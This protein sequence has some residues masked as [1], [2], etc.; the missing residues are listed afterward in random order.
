MRRTSK[1]LARVGILAVAAG[2]ILGT[3]LAIGTANAA[4]PP[5]ITTPNNGLGVPSD[6]GTVTQIPAP[7]TGYLDDA[8]IRVTS[9]NP[10]ATL[11][12]TLSD[13]NNTA[14]FTSSQFMGSDGVQTATGGGKT[15]T[16][17]AD[18][19][20]NCD[21]EVGNTT[22]DAVGI[23]IQDTSN[24][25]TA[26]SKVHFNGLFFMEC[27]EI[28]I[29]TTAVGSNLCRTQGSTNTA[30][31][32]VVQYLEDGLGVANKNIAA[33]INGSPAAEFTGTSLVDPAHPQQSTCSTNTSG[34]C[35]FFVTDTV[36]NDQFRLV[37]GFTTAL[38][39]FPFPRIN[40]S[41]VA[42]TDCA[43]CID[44]VVRMSTNAVTANRLD[45]VDSQVIGPSSQ[46]TAFQQDAEPGD[47]V[48]N[49]YYLS[50]G[51]TVQ[52]GNF[53]C[54][55]PQEG[56]N[57]D[58]GENLANTS[59]TLAVDHG[60]FTNAC[61]GDTYGGC[62]FTTPPASG[63]TVGNIA[64]AGTDGKTITV[65]TDN[66][67]FVSVYLAI[68]RDTDFD[69][70]GYVVAHV[71]DGSIAPQVPHDGVAGQNC[72]T[73]PQGLQPTLAGNAGYPGNT[74]DPLGL[75]GAPIQ[76]KFL[77]GC[78]VDTVWTTREQPL[79][80][81][82]AK[83]SVIAPITSPSNTVQAG[84]NNFAATDTT[85]A[86][87]PDIDRVDF[88]VHI[89][90][91]FGNLTSDVDPFSGSGNQ[92][93]ITKTGPGWLYVCG[94]YS[95]VSACTSGASTGTLTAQSDG[96]TKQVDSHVIGSYN[97]V[98]SNGTLGSQVRYQA[99][100][101]NAGGPAVINLH[102]PCNANIPGSC[103]GGNEAAPGVN[104]GT[105][106]DVLSWSAPTTQF[107]QVIG[108]VVSTKA[109]T[110]TA[111]T[112]TLT[113]NFYNQL[114]QPVVTFTTSPASKVQT[115][116]A[117]TVSATVVDQFK[118]GI[119]AQLVQFVRSGANE[120]TCTPIQ[121]GPGNYTQATNTLGVA[122]YTF[123][124]DGAGADT[125]SVVVTTPNGNQLAR[126]TVPVT[127][128]GV[129]THSTVE[130]PTVNLTSFHAHHL[131]VH[132]STS[133]ALGA[134]RTVDVYRLVN[135]IK[136]LV[137]QTHT[138]PKGNASLTFHGLRS[139]AVWRVAAKVINLGTQYRS[140]YA[141]AVSHRVK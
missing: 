66:F 119:V 139:G 20:G 39:P 134:G 56:P 60:F 106:T 36:D 14:F 50:G 10:G 125:I 2:T 68:G 83:Y 129:S 21:V 16:C 74:V 112:D 1:A 75:I 48:K 22:S 51:C 70:N 17:V 79:N 8:F 15:A 64:P 73:S 94:G 40:P 132:I 44:E 77:P 13:P 32:Y 91:Q 93:T 138:G 4:T 72:A 29:D 96:T 85:T 89:T 117:V 76:G 55:G 33:V 95:A 107:D 97:N 103:T 61:T 105:Q 122:G 120:A 18:A 37:A 121:N 136:H 141:I 87:V 111:Q 109:G 81:G 27:P 23:A 114:A 59:V 62:T 25:T 131:T 30:N 124:C 38:Q 35:T 140:E 118:N 63:G 9:V 82:T 101:T 92:P 45:L 58:H 133:P 57:S 69:G 26:I 53:S 100:D 128:T 49:T 34:E 67:G 28:G 42:G 54:E 78:P 12:L 137:G 88:V 6:H 126:G 46:S 110:A 130:R 3:P 47:V 116:T 65:K 98:A 104:D 71:T 7:G 19:G 41:N 24:N 115:S 123:S 5:T 86:N 102:Y 80:G 90:D 127:F 52:T 11:D 135:G 113:L 31:Q 84:E 108:F 43:D 99:D